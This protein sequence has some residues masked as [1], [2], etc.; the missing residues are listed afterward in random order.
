MIGVSTTTMPETQTHRRKRNLQGIPADMYE[1]MMN[2]LE[3]LR[4]EL[5]GID[6][7]EEEMA[8]VM[9][10]V[11]EFDRF[12]KEKIVVRSKFIWL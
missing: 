9:K 11:D 10:N 5:S 6:N 1:R 4:E 2:S 8:E 3:A 12:L 7:T